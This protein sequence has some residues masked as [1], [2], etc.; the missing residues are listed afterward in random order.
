M[1]SKLAWAFIVNNAGNL[2]IL[3]QNAPGEDVYVL[4]VDGF[5][6]NNAIINKENLWPLNIPHRYEDEV[7]DNH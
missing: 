2:V 7:N 4:P 3:A 6:G 5:Y 1:K